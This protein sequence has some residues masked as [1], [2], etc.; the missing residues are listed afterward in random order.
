MGAILASLLLKSPKQWDSEFAIPLPKE[1]HKVLDESIVQ[2]K[3]VFIIG[4]VHGCLDELKDLLEKV[5]ALD[6]NTIVILCGDLVNKGPKSTQVLEYVQEIGAF[7]VRGNH[8]EAALDHY[9]KSR[10]PD[11]VVPKKWH[12]IEDLTESHVDFM[13]NLPYTI[14]VPS[15]NLMVVHG[16]LMPNTKLE[17]QQPIHMTNLRN[18][19]GYGTDHVTGI[20]GKT[21]GEMWGK[22]WNGP[23]H[24]Y[25]GHDASRGLQKFDFATGLDTYC[26]YGGNL[27]GVIANGAREFH[28]VTARKVYRDKGKN[29][30]KEAASLS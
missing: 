21:E 9:L 19:V 16:G 5:G 3:R 14:S 2:D 11:Y 27:T 18:V 17:Q 24:V 7:A 6:G 29:K 28:S 4:D 22:I 30:A 12:W 10:D 1:F 26:V 25:Y 13:M 8:E 15:L 23:Q 20:K